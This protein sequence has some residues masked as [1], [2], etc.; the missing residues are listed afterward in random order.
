LGG[1]AAQRVMREEDGKMMM[2]EKRR[3]RER[4]GQGKVAVL[5]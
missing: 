4:E 3:K 2:G 5:L 1:K